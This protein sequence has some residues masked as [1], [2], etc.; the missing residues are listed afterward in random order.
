LDGKQQHD[1][2]TLALHLNLVTIG[3]HPKHFER[4]GAQLDKLPRH[5]G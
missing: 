4:V 1:A 3:Q 2:I 5:K